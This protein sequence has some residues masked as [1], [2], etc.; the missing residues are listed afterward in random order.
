MTSISRSS[1]D[2]P[3]TSGPV[4]LEVLPFLPE[5]FHDGGDADTWLAHLAPWGWTGVRDWGSEGWD[6]GNW[7]YQAVALYDSPFELYYA[8]A[9]YTEGDV[10][11]E[12]WATREERDTSVDLLALSYWSHSDR[13]PADA[14]DPSTP[15]SD[16]PARFRG[17]YTPEDTT[18]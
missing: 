4:P 5:D 11:V 15:P 8:L 16:I 12:A 3:F 13:G 7:P 17:P 10:S 9:V 18:A 1:S 14:P 2:R 6:L